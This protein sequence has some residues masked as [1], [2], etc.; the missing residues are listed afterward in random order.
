MQV[1]NIINIIILPYVYLKCKH[2]K[3]YFFVFKDALIYN[4]MLIKCHWHL[5]CIMFEHWVSFN[6]SLCTMLSLKNI[7]QTL[8]MCLKPN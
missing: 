5:C 6:T 8:D 2:T 7:S 3:Q 4:E 1:Y